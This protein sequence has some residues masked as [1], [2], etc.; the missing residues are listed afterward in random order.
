MLSLSSK[1][2]DCIEMIMKPQNSGRWCNLQFQ[3]KFIE[4]WC[5]KDYSTDFMKKSGFW[6]GQ[7]FLITVLYRL[8]FKKH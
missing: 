3:N 6:R 7:N 2:E 1:K 8:L 4:D 5:F